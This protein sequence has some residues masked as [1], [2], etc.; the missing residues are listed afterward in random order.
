MLTVLG[1]LTLVVWLGL[2]FGHGWFWRTDQRL[3][4]SARPVE[5]PSV[6][7]VVPARDEAAVLPTTLPALLAQRYPGRARV[8]L[9]DDD[10]GD[11]TGDL[12][13]RLGGAPDALPLTVVTP[14][15]LP[16]GWT[17]KLW[18]AARGVAE[19]GTAEFVLLT[20]ADIEHGPGSLET[21]VAACGERDLVSQMAVLRTETPW[22]RLIVPAFVYFFAMLYP[23]RRV[24]NPRSR[25]AAAAG[26]CVLVRRGALERAGGLAAV[27]GAVIDDVALA[28]AVSAAGGRTWL[29]FATN[30]RSVRPYPR[31]SD[32]W[33]MV[34]RTAYTQLRHSP[35]V[36]AGTVV[37]LALVFLA[38]PVLT[39]TGPSWP[40]LAAW[41]LMA[42]T[43]VP[44]ARYYRQWPVLGALLP[45]TALL[46]TVMTL[47]SAR[48][49]FAGRGAGWKGRNYLST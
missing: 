10:S 19:A 6:A 3:P 22:E 23:F 26:G 43:F 38:P 45:V 27:R 31:L 8:I 30:V 9:V 15:P 32:L 46:Y 35:L 33:Q 34:A 14:D 28:R 39:F 41:V 29:G 13:R 2:A 24:N 49:H 5:W 18:A 7:V 25:V 11:G 44:I 36:L 42:A 47:D 20:D 12:A 48:R 17:G 37:G 1:W 16:A 21:L 40:A 4:P